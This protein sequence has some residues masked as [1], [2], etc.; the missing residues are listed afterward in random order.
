LPDLIR[1]IFSTKGAFS[2]FFFIFHLS[3]FS[4][5][6]FWKGKELQSG[7]HKT[8]DGEI[9]IRNTTDTIKASKAKLY[10]KPKKIILSGNLSLVRQG[11]LVTGDSG[12]FFPSLKLAQIIGHAVINS[13][14]GVMRS[15]AFDYNMN[16]KLL[17]SNSFTEGTAN[18]IRF[19]ADKSQIF[20]ATKN[21]KLIG[22]AV[23]ENDTIKG[24]A[25]TIYLDKANN[26]LRMS[27]RAKIISKKKNDEITGRF[28]EIDLAT[29]K[30]S[31]IDGSQ[32]KRKDGSLKAKKIEQK[33]EDYE[34][35]E[36]VEVNS[37]DSAVVSYGQK[38]F[39]KKTGMAMSGNTK[40]RI[41]DKEKKELF[42]YSPFLIT[43][44]ADSVEK[45]SFFKNTNL[46]GQFD[47]YGD[48]LSVIKN[49][50]SKEIHLI[51]NAHIQ[52]DSMYMEADTIEI[53]QD[54]LKQVIKAKRN[55]LMIMITKP[56]RV[57]TITAAFI[58][59]TKS[60]SVSEMYA[61]GDSESFLWN[62]EKSSLGINHTVSPIQKALIRNKKISRV[63]TKGST[64]SNFQPIN[65]V[66][67]GYVNN[68]A[69][70][71]KE[72]YSKDTIS[73]G[74]V[75]IKNFLNRVKPK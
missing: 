68:A 40:T 60:D 56:N 18:G 38:A 23:W 6:I 52:N 70:K 35:T 28:I 16:S 43:S 61:N 34:L 32:I 25:D 22:H 13:Q 72:T 1:K 21:I 4:Q 65:K 41:R 17:S 47:G 54:S 59:L 2:L 33:G 3:A 66:D 20:P 75:P 27:K 12:I 58:Q 14:D 15:N 7:D 49:K 11:S 39:T 26:V 8:I 42:I 51:L 64:K 9:V 45:Y 30:I 31:K 74:L 19:K 10:N 71:L 55:A 67:Y 48:S 46:R 37:N 53:F 63:T 73:P 44:K 69:I 36:D 57:N 29:N 5:D 50:L 62:D 24:M